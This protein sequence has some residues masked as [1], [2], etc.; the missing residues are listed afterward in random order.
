MVRSKLLFIFILFICVSLVFLGI[1]IAFSPIDVSEKIV[2]IKKGSSASEIAN[3]LYK[4]GIIRSRVLF[5]IYLKFNSS[6]KLLSFGKYIFKGTLSVRDVVKILVEGRVSLTKVTIREGL[7][8]EEALLVIAKQTKTDFNELKRLSYN[9][10]FIKELTNFYLNSLEGF[11]YPE[12]YF[13]DND[14]NEK[15]VLKIITNYFFSQI[16]KL[17]FSKQKKLSFYEILILASIVQKETVINKEKPLIA[18]VYLN[19]L[20]E[21]Q[22]LQADPTIIY[23]LKKQGIKRKRVYFKDL[24]RKSPYNTYLNFGL[25]PSPITSP[26]LSSVRSVLKP[27]T[28][29]YFFFMATRDGS[30]IFAKTFAEHIKN[31]EKR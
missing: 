17:D 3:I 29:K 25:P 12:T 10:D 1:F 23:F 30:H 8:L 26:T 24:K 9:R 16:S 14:I 4:N 21:N 5:T 19:R 27:K 20:R 6:D 18:S 13:V 22:K 31:R 15:Q 2:V 7:T 28:S 11:L